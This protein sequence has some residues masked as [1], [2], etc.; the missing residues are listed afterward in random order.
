[1]VSTFGKIAGSSPK[2]DEYVFFVA[3]SQHDRYE[4]IKNVVNLQNFVANYALRDYPVTEADLLHRGP[5]AFH[6]ALN[7]VNVCNYNLGW[8]AVGMCTHAM[9]EAVTHASTS[10]CTGQSSPTSVTCGGCSP[11]PTCG[12]IAMK[13]VATRACDYMRSASPTTAVTCCTAR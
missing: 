1:M 7:T 4:L 13:L 11:T 6:V 8:G 9:Y 3:D 10:T 2:N 12:L 5:D